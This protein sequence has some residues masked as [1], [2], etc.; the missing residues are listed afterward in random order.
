[1]PPTNHRETT[2]TTLREYQYAP[3]RLNG[4]PLSLVIASGPY[5]TD[6]NLDYAPLDAL[7]EEMRKLRPDVLILVRT[8]AMI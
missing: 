5:T 7:C 1:M 3:S 6:S 8:V 2:V 4:E